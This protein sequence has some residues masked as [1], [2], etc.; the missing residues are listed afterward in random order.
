LAHHRQALR[1]ATE[2]RQPGDRASALDGLAH[3]EH[4]LHQYELA[5][6]HWQEALDILTSLGIDHTE[7]GEA[8]VSTIHANLAAVAVADP[9]A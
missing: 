1:L 8:S 5:R 7:D 6:R 4:A 2:L 9:R 3:A